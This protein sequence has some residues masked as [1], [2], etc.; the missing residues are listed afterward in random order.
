MALDLGYSKE[1]A[2]HAIKSNWAEVRITKEIKEF[3][4]HHLPVSSLKSGRF[5]VDPLESKKQCHLFV[6]LFIY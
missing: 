1:A 5:Y 4:Q 2:L 6:Y 3:Q